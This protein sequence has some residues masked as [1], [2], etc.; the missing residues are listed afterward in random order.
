MGS[1]RVGRTSKLSLE[2]K[3]ELAARAY[4][5]HNHTRYEDRLM[6]AGPLEPDLD[7]PLYRELRARAHEEVDRFLERRRRKGKS[8]ARKDRQGDPKS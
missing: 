4:I 2:E 1:G 3:A 5:R 7:D 6:N 8:A